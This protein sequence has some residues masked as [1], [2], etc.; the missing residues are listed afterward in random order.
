MI[1]S[2]FV[3]YYSRYLVSFHFYFKI[4]YVLA[5]SCF[6]TDPRTKKSRFRALFLHFT[7]S[8][9]TSGPWPMA[10]RSLHG[11]T[12]GT[13]TGPWSCTLSSRTRSTG[14]RALNTNAHSVKMLQ[15]AIQITQI[16]CRHMLPMNLCL[17]VIFFVTLTCLLLLYVLLFDFRNSPVK[18]KQ[19]RV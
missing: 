2:P 16:F 14:H 7:W 3:H 6:L 19:V 17:N 8:L 5:V 12:G 18:L 13:W 9:A 4:L 15:L 11:T 1:H 10:S